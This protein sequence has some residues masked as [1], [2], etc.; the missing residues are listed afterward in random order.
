M[1]V[2]YLTTDETTATLKC[3]RGESMVQIIY[4]DIHQILNYLL[5]F[6]IY[7]KGVDHGGLGVLTH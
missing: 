4:T 1:P 7:F 3:M 6:G 2:K 5:T